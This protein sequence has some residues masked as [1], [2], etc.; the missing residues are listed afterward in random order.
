MSPYVTTRPA[1]RILLAVRHMLAVAG[2][3][4]ALLIPSSSSPDNAHLQHE[5]TV[6]QRQVSRLKCG[7]GLL[8]GQLVSLE[9]RVSVLERG[10]TPSVPPPDEKT[11]GPD[12]GC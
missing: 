8:N 5:I 7:N 6:L 10:Q 3:A 4:G 1:R 9:R 12:A 11:S 2:V